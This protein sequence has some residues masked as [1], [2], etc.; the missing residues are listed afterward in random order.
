[1]ALSLILGILVGGVMG[2]TGAG[3]GIL[4]VPA[5][6]GGMGWTVQQV[7][8]LTPKERDSYGIGQLPESLG[9]A[10][11][12]MSKSELVRETLG[13]HVFENFLH[14]KRKEWD[15]YRT[16]VTKWEIEKYLPIL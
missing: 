10:L 13:N 3:G 2:L 4:A 12:V 16:N 5:L 7:Y 8:E 6:V 9:H 11:M 1:M 15:E 14:V